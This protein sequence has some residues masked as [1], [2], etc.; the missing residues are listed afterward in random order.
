MFATLTAPLAAA[1]FLSYFGFTVLVA[2]TLR[3]KHMSPART[4][5]LLFGVLV[6]GAISIGLRT[7]TFALS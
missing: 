1:L 6:V 7:V 5:V 2:T 4:Q 3:V